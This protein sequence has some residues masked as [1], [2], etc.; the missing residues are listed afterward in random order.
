[1]IFHMRFTFV[2]IGWER[3]PL[4]FKDRLL[5]FAMMLVMAAMMSALGCCLLFVMML[6]LSFIESI[7]DF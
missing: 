1:M 5:R 2:K 7:V 4:A 6:G 3:T